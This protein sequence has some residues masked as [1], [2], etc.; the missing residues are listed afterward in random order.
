MVQSLIRRFL[1]KR[2]LKKLRIEARSV[3]HV[4]NLNKG[5]ELKIIELQQRINEFVNEKKNLIHNDIEI[6][7]YKNQISKLE[8]DIKNLKN[9]LKQ[10]EIDFQTL[11]Q[12]LTDYK[13]SNEKLTNEV[14]KH[15]KKINEL[16]TNHA[17]IR[18]EFDPKLLEEAVAQK[19]KQLLSKFDKEKKGLMETIENERASRQQLLRKYMA[20]EEKYQSGGRGEEED[21]KSPGLLLFIYPHSSL[22]VFK[23]VQLSDFNCFVRIRHID[24]FTDDAL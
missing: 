3:E 8:I 21:D 15:K 13:K 17:K 19:E 20:L 16:L 5:L 18:Q 14:E 1:A 12:D 11:E 9:D 10:K 22:F 6:C 2:E 23:L 7:E 4:T 24:G